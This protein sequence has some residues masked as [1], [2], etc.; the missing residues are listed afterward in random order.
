MFF[1][2]VFFAW[3]VFLFVVEW[4][5]TDLTHVLVFCKIF[6]LMSPSVT[7]S[8]RHAEL[9]SASLSD[10]DPESSSGWLCLM[11]LITLYFKTRS[12]IPNQAAPDITVHDIQ[13]LN[14][15]FLCLEK[16]AC[17]TR[18][19]IKKIS[20]PI[21]RVRLTFVLVKSHKMK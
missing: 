17:R 8:K 6:G 7:L 4:C 15:F 10:K 16:N 20:M 12:S 1:Y 3:V 18:W 9:V 21:L 2:I 13:S 11:V 14:S 19:I 5:I